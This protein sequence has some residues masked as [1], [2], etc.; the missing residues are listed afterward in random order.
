MGLRRCMGS[1]GRV[2]RFKIQERVFDRHER[3]VGRVPWA[4]VWMYSDGS[5]RCIAY[6]QSSQRNDD[7]L[8]TL[9]PFHLRFLVKK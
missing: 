8:L 5:G 3:G 6:G 4:R 1:E 2:E 9:S 7:F